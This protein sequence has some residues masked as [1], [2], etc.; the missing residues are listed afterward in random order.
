[1]MTNDAREQQAGVDKDHPV[2][3]VEEEHHTLRE[4][5]DT[6]EAAT[7]CTGLL[8]EMLVLPKML[9]EHFAVEEQ[10]GG[11]YEDLQKRRPV[12]TS[13][14]NELRDEHKVILDEFDA[15]RL[16]LNGQIEAEEAVEAIPES[17]RRD[18]SR[19]LER[20]RGHERKESSMI[21]EV[22]Y[23]DEGGFG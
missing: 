5:L 17:M 15:I 18:V 11:L 6:I 9:V 19:W 21:G 8:G 4:Q 13:Q 2:V 12:L 14:L 3:R 23:T 16:R 1:M 22:Y 10:T 7:T 20:L